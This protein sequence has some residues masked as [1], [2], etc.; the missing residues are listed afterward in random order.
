MCYLN[1]LQKRAFEENGFTLHEALL[2]ARDRL[3]LN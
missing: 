1:M 2:N 3:V